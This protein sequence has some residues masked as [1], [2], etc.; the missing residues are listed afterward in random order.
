MAGRWPSQSNSGPAVAV[1]RDSQLRHSTPSDDSMKLRDRPIFKILEQGEIT[2]RCSSKRI[3]RGTISGPHPRRQSPIHR[4]RFPLDLLEISIPQLD[5]RVVS[6]YLEGLCPSIASSQN[7]DSY[8]RKPRTKTPEQLVATS[9][10]S[11]MLGWRRSIFLGPTTTSSQQTQRKLP[12]AF[13]IT[14]GR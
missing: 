3:G 13:A 9:I 1:R 4:S 6:C 5:C 8:G 2:R 14:E 10:S 12:V 11:T 7:H